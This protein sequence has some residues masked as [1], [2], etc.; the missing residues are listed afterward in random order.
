MEYFFLRKV[1]L[2]EDKRSKDF[3]QIALFDIEY[4]AI[5]L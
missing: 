5:F 3:Q 1:M 4:G 2:G